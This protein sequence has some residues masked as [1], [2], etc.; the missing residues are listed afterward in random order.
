M[1]EFAIVAPLMLLLI[2]GIID[3]GRAIY[4]YGTIIESA[5]E[6]VRVAIQASTPLPSDTDVLKAAQSH[7]QSIILANPC[8]NGPLPP[9]SGAGA[10]NPPPSSG[11]IFITQPNPPSTVQAS[12]PL[13]APGG[14]TPAAATASCSA[15]NPASSGTYPLQVTIRY[16]YSLFTPLL[17]Q[18]LPTFILQAYAVEYTEY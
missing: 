6:G 18:L 11:W 1:T 10:Q 4:V 7:A 8:A 16:T 15:I 13:N 12:P 9:I 5:H 17:Y 3:F 14:S 2:F